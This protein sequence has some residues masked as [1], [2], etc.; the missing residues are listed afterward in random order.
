MPEDSPSSQ[1]RRQALAELQDSACSLAQLYNDYASRFRLWALA[2]R[3]VD[4]AKHDDAKFIQQLWDVALRQV[5]PASSAHLGE[6]A[7]APEEGPAA[8]CAHCAPRAH[9][10]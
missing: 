2:L 10:H 8:S 4:L 7:C 1:D 5:C 3:A 6:T 9:W